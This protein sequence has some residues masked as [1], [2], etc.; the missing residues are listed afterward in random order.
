MK[1]FVEPWSRCFSRMPDSI[2]SS[3]DKVCELYVVK[4]SLTCA[5]IPQYQTE[6]LKTIAGSCIVLPG[7]W[8]AHFKPSCF[9]I[10]MYH[11][12]KPCWSPLF[13]ENTTYFW[14]DTKYTFVCCT[15]SSDVSASRASPGWPLR[16]S[17]GMYT[18]NSCNIKKR[19]HSD[20]D[21]GNA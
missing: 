9:Q 5:D 17:I 10:E 21:G 6:P 11:Q 20:S 16:S 1:V 4:V 8:K 7:M 18:L 12:S 3:G 13:V 15:L 14:A 2:N 19:A